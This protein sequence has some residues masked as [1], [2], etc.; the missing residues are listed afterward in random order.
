M[1]RVR[2][3][4]AIPAVR[5]ARRQSRRG[6]DWAP[7]AG[8][9][10]ASWPTWRSRASAGERRR[11]AATAADASWT[12]TGREC[13]TSG[14]PP[15]PPYRTTRTGVAAATPTTSCPRGSYCP[16]P[17]G[18]GAAT[19]PW[20]KATESQTADTG[21]ADFDMTFNWTSCRSSHAAPYDSRKPLE[22]FI[23]R[24]SKADGTTSYL[25]PYI[26]SE[27]LTGLL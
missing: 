22:S 1:R 23:E 3:D 2:H 13:T 10:R 11:R 17:T 25:A 19:C 20:R 24:S 26:F 21:A 4:L 6:R 16:Y 7:R 9:A 27:K 5:L 14:L 12:T 15:G 18:R 8:W